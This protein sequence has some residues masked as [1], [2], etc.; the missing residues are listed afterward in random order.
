MV[1]EIIG[2]F[3]GNIGMIPMQYGLLSY[4]ILDKIGKN[5]RLF[6]AIWQNCEIE[7]GDW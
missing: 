4:I 7:Q 6:I 5:S 2:Y 1:L 3:S